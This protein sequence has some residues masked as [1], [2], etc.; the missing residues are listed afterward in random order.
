MDTK[1][2]DPEALLTIP[3]DRV[4]TPQ[5]YLI[6]GGTLPEKFLAKLRMPVA[7]FDKSLPYDD[8]VR[9]RREKGM[10]V[11]HSAW[12]FF[13]VSDPSVILKSAMVFRLS[14]LDEQI[15]EVKRELPE[16]IGVYDTETNQINTDPEILKKYKYTAEGKRSLLFEGHSLQEGHPSRR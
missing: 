2:I 4:L 16:L 15:H 14:G 6:I 10:I 11:S 13:G 3:D 1:I 5:E 8:V 12:L 7:L 9:L